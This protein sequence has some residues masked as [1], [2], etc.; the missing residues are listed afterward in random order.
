MREHLRRQPASKPDAGLTLPADPSPVVCGWA[1]LEKC[2]DRGAA[3]EL[4]KSRGG[5]ALAAVK[6]APPPLVDTAPRTASG[7]A[8]ATCLIGEARSRGFRDVKMAGAVAK[9][10]EGG[11]EPPKQRTAEG[12][13]FSSLTPPLRPE[14]MEV[15]AAQGF[16][17]ATPVQAAAIGLLAGNKDVAVEACTGSGKTLAFVLPMV[18]ILA[19]ASKEQS[20]RKHHVGA[21]VVSPTREL[22]RQIFDVAAPFMA[23]LPD[24]APP[25]L[26]VGGTDVNEDVRAFAAAGA[27]ALIGTPGRLDDLMLRS[28]AFDAKRCELLVLDEADRLL[29]MGFA[30]AINA[31]I[32]RLPKQRRT[33]LF[34]ATQTDEVEEL[35]RA[36]LRNPVRV[37]VRDSAAQAAA[38]AAKASG[39]PANSAAARG[40]LPAQLKLL[41]KVCRVDERLWRLREFL[42]ENADK[43]TIVYFLTCACVDYFATAMCDG[44]PASP[45]DDVDVVA[46]HGKMKQSQ[47]EQALGRFAA[48]AGGCLLCTDVAARG[49]DIPGVD[50]VVQFDAPQDPA[51]FVHRVG[52][53][54]R[55]GRDGSALL[56]LSPHESSYVEFLRVRHIHLREVDGLEDRDEGAAGGEGAGNAGDAKEAGLKALR[57]EM[58]GGGVEEEEDEE[59]EEG[60]EEESEDEESEEEGSEEEDSEEED[61][62][63]EGSDEDAADTEAV[64]G[65]NRL[66][67][68][69]RARSEKNR[70]AMEKGVRAFVSYLRGYKEHHCRFIFRFKELELARL[71]RSL[72]LL[73]L[74]R[75]KEIR[76][77]P[78]S[79]LK[80]F[81]ESSVNPD[82]VPFEDRAREKQR[83]RA[84]A[85]E[86][87]RRAANPEANA[88]SRKER[89]KRKREEAAAVA[90]KAQNEKRLTA[91]KRRQVEAQDDFDDLDDDYR[92]LKKLKKGKITEEEFDFEMGFEQPDGMSKRDRELAAERAGKKHHH[93]QPANHGALQ[94]AALKAS[95]RKPRDNKPRHLKNSKAKGGGRSKKAVKK[96]FKKS[97]GAK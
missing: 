31:I 81:T 77:A 65:G 20:F 12:P 47:R 48:G 92:A 49:L 39:L 45:G 5:L 43:K 10:A 95:M 67:D 61:S 19:R 28:N 70:E 26:L 66:C 30:R 29:S 60:S 94:G 7:L 59:D 80:G 87:A 6:F 76:K 63:E 24:M 55:M 85:E 91:A 37:T 58:S 17:R 44:A 42:K 97:G 15:L 1:G 34:S 88:D 90:A 84:L 83:Q 18:E 3:D 50:W 53:T 23:T 35:A 56:F 9:G 38:N 69:L 82:A 57:E 73:R 40:K 13:R 74:P 79:S 46:L 32:A 22:A 78:K 36:G 89:E 68:E 75:M 33:G 25:M 93:K 11:S 62:D 71:A 16:E 41:Y 21:V 64:E 8:R 96:A 72:G 2:S 51:A 4:V 14:S 86:A 27:A 52:R 54:A